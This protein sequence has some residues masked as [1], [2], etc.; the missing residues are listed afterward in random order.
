[1][2]RRGLPGR[3]CCPGSVRSFRRHARSCGGAVRPTRKRHAI[4]LAARFTRDSRTTLPTRAPTRS[5]PREYVLAR[6]A[7]RHRPEAHWRKPTILWPA[8]TATGTTS[9]R[10]SWC[11]VSGRLIFRVGWLG[12]W[13]AGWWAGSWC[14]GRMLVRLWLL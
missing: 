1:M 9:R 4:V 11:G 7:E 8:A 13:G 5:F 2:T 6:S 3:S 12:C 10:P 14:V